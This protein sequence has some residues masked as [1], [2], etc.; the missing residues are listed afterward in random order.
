MWE[1]FMIGLIGLFVS[2]S[3]D[4]HP[5]YS[6]GQAAPRK[7]LRMRDPDAGL[8]MTMGKG[9]R[10]LQIRHLNLSSLLRQ[11]PHYQLIRMIY[12]FF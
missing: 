11:T 12:P 8:A 7:M 10:H 3:G 4:C 6:S 9:I 2:G 1:F 5:D